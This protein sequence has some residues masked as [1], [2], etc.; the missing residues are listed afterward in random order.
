MKKPNPYSK[1]FRSMCDLERLKGEIQ[2]KLTLSD[3]E[4]L[5]EF[6]KEVLAGKGLIQVIFIEGR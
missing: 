2:T 4:K 3:K 6:L 1:E 5:S